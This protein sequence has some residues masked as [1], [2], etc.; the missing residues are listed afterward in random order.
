MLASEGWPHTGSLTDR[1]PLHREDIE[2]IKAMSA[3]SR[4][5]FAGRSTRIPTERQKARNRAYNL[6]NGLKEPP[7]PA[8][9]WWPAPIG[10]QVFR[11]KKPPLVVMTGGGFL[12]CATPS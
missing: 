10:A 7:R 5:P 4:R 1:H 12:R 6:R 9:E 8:K 3:P 11:S 2:E